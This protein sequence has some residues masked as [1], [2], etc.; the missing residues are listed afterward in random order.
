MPLSAVFDTAIGLIL[1]YVILSLACTVINE[2][3]ATWLQLRAKTLRI[4]LANLIDIPRL[5]ADFDNH[6][7]IDGPKAAVNGK[8]V[9]YMSGSTFALALLGSLD[10]T[11][12]L[13]GFADVS[14]AIQNLP[15][16]NIRDTLLMQITTAQGDLEKLRDNVAAWFDDAMDRVGGVY[17]RY[18]KWI[19]LLVGLGLALAINADTF[20]V[21][22]ALWHDDA[23]RAQMVSAGSDIIAKAPLPQTMSEAGAATPLSNNDVVAK[24]QQAEIELRPLPLGWGATSP[25]WTKTGL[26][27]LW[28]VIEKIFGLL[29]TA[30]ALSLGAPFWFDVLSKF[31]NVRGAGPKPT[32][33]VVS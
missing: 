9:S 22:T 31:M 23:L 24:L 19:S 15:D 20:E 17:K 1:M 29:V 14:Q 28:S 3:V 5:K 18:L 8:H 13:P 32:A 11:K 26:S 16:S 10:P 12:P 27:M 6:G 30:L 4:S 7:L 33:T 2:Y 25:I 21:A